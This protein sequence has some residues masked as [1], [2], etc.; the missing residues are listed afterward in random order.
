[1]NTVSANGFL[2]RL[3]RLYGVQTA[4]YDTHHERKQASPEA[5]LAILISL[6]CPVIALKDAETAC[7]E[8]ELALWR[9]LIELVIVVWDGSP[10]SVEL[11]LPLRMSGDKLDCNL[12]LESGEEVRWTQ[13]GDSRE[14]TA[15][16][17]VT[18]ETYVLKH[19][20]LPGKLPH[21]YHRL[22]VNLANLSAE[23]LIISAPS[24]AYTPDSSK[25]R[26]WGAFLPLYALHT[27]RSWGAGD[28]SDL[29]V[30]MDWVVGRGGNFVATLPLL[31]VF[32]DVIFEPSPYLPV[33]RRFW[34][35]FYLDVNGIPELNECPEAAALISSSDFQER[36]QALRHLETVDYRQQ[37]ALKRRVLEELVRFFFSRN[38]P[39]NDEFNRFLARNPEINDYACFRAAMERCQ[40]PWQGWPEPARSGNLDKR[41]YS[42]E[43]RRYYLYA[44]WL[45]HQQMEDISVEARKKGVGLSLDLPVGV[46]PDGYDAWREKELFVTDAVSGAPPDLVFTRGQDWRFPPFHPEKIRRQGYRYVIDCLRHHMSRAGILR[47]DHVMGFHRMFCFP[48]GLGPSEGV[49]LRYQ[50][51]E[52]YAI[53]SLE[54]HRNRTVIIGEDLGTVPRY[55]RPAMKKHGLNRMYIL[56]YE[57]AAIGDKKL[58]PLPRDAVVALNTH[59]MPPFA[60]FW[61]GLDIEERL[62]LGILDKTGAEM[63]RRD[64]IRIKKALTVFLREK[65]L[66]D[67]NADD[68]PSVIRA[69]LSFLASGKTR[70]LQVNLEDLWLE[71]KPHNIPS[72]NHEYPNWQ[73]KTH[74]SLEE[75]SKMPMVLDTLHTVNELRGKMGG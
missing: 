68:I 24:C 29:S 57:L 37:M 22:R 50:A 10:A 23:S 47:I 30:L 65:G 4:Y 60:A 51:E 53:L 69:C 11:K 12:R 44:Q 26:I 6:G 40:T 71:L 27:E 20:R 46:H 63:E 52:L 74:Y 41:D 31:P 72:T 42:E 34:N 28:L 38:S 2:Y 36:I 45:I 5:L 18:G 48:K 73:R 21:G 54:S 75:F 33:S 66:L 14:I 25:D 49:Y 70:L 1:M 39:R 56:Y 43:S 35:G 16:T 8:R 59:D 67:E 13:S 61:Q 3:A 58:P 55:V 15:G 19:L 64:F 62:R 17:D 7:R 32:Q 9:Q